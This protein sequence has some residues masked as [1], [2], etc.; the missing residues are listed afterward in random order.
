MASI[1][2]NYLMGIL[3]D[4]N[5]GFIRKIGLGFSIIV[6]LSVLIYYKYFGF[7]LLNT[8]SIFHFNSLTKDAAL[9]IHLPLGISFFTFHGLTYVIDIYRKDAH[10]SHNPLNTG[11]YTLFFPQLI[12][13]PIVR[14]KDIDEQLNKR[15]INKS[16]IYIGIQRFIIGFAKKILIANSVGVIADKIYQTN[17]AYMTP[18]MLWLA[19]LCY[20]LQIFFDFSGYSDMA[21]GLAKVFGFDF[22][23]NFNYPYAARSIRD[24]WRRWH[25]SLSNFFKDYVYIPLGGNRKGSFRNYL[26]LFIVFALTGFWHGASWNYLL[27]G[28]FHG[29]FLVVERIGLGKFLD[30]IPKVLQHL[31]TL[32]IVLIGWVLFR[33]EDFNLLKLILKKMFFINSDFQYAY[34]LWFYLNSYTFT[35]LSIGILFSFPIYQYVRK[36]IKINTQNSTLRVVYDCGY[37]ALF[38]ISLAEMA[39]TTFNP[40]IYFRF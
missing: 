27:W 10:V 2:F 31:Y 28:I 12:A 18:K 16:R 26:N 40:F 8:D 14:Y 7:L 35:T 29:T 36:K 3:I 5:E 32:F 9:K 11:L 34:N 33:I 24:F 37:L 25:I 13:G 30:K 4:K 21:I 17:P 1:L 19:A 23:E 15:V 6:N 22:L 20:T 39:S 38:V